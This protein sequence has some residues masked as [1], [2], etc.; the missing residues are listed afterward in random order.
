MSP[1]PPAL[2]AIA[3][4]LLLAALLAFASPHGAAA[5]GVFQV[6]RRFTR[7]GGHGGGNI[8]VHLAHD[9]SRRGRLLAA[10]DVPLG[11]LGLPTDTGYPILPR[12]PA[13]CW[14]VCSR[15]K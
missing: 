13:Y 2:R 11:G 14:S 9:V 7:A 12:L 3:A 8:T 4:A 6:H 1:L 10:A 15:S 5:T